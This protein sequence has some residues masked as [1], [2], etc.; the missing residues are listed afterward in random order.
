MAGGW[1]MTVGRVQWP[2][3]MVGGPLGA[4]EGAERLVW[5]YR[6]RAA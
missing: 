2:K 4:W 1:V 5:K 3:M 6:F